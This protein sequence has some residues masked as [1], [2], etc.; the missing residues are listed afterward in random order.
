MDGVFVNSVGSSVRHFDPVLEEET[1]WRVFS[2]TGEEE[3]E[4]GVD[5]RLDR[6]TM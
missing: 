5:S 3:E 2:S 4:E 6:N 1:Y